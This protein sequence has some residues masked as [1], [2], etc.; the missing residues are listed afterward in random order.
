MKLDEEDQDWFE[1][2]REHFSEIE[3]ADPLG[4]QSRSTQEAEE[5]GEV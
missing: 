5:R 2:Q 3:D 4:E 1:M